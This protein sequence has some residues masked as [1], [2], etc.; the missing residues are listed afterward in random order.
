[1]VVAAVAFTICAL[2]LDVSFTAA[3]LRGLAIA[4]LVSSFACTSFGLA[5]GSLGLR[6]RNVTLFADMVAGSMLL[7]SGANVPLERL[8]GWIQAVSNVLPLTHGIEAGRRLADGETL[9]DVSGLLAA[10]VGIGTCYLVL[11]LVLLRFFEQQGRRS[12]TLEAF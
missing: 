1:M 4:A 5:L 10:E 8:P 12:A 3:E 9:G 2:I 11:G 7:L 6:G